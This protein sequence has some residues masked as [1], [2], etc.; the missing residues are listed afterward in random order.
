MARAP[1]RSNSRNVSD[2]DQNI[3]L[4]PFPF[5]ITFKVDPELSARVL[6]VLAAWSRCGQQKIEPARLRQA[7]LMAER[8][9]A[10]RHTESVNIEALARK[11]GVAY[12]YFRRAFRAQTGYSPWKYVLHL[13]LKHAR[14]LLVASDATLDDIA[15]SLGFSSGFHFSTAFKQT[16]GLPP[17]RWRRQMRASR[18]MERPVAK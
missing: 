16:Y 15:V 9:L 11:L 2:H 18:A 5:Q 8:H 17:D 13:R 1:L 10:E 3:L 6:G 7:V 12:S 4:L 14:R